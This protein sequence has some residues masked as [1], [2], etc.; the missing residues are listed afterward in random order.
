M[1][2]DD[3]LVATATIPSIGPGKTAQVS[4]TDPTI[5]PATAETRYGINNQN[6]TYRLVIDPYNEVPEIDETN[7]QYTRTVPILYNG[8][9]GKRW[10]YNG[11]DINT[12][13][14][15]DGQYGIAYYAQ[16]DTTYASGTNGWSNYTVTFNGTQPSIPENA[17]PVKVYLYAPY[18]WDN[19]GINPEE[20]AALTYL[21]IQFNDEVFQPGNYTSWYWDQSNFGGYP[22]Y[23]YGLLVYDVTEYYHKTRTTL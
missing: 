8:Y 4:I 10:A 13:E 12:I 15:Y 3:Q 1:Y 21:T 23:K 22:T 16:P 2:A 14:V 11:S 19:K 6:V 7:N 18:N 9:K 17:T 20:G 5:R